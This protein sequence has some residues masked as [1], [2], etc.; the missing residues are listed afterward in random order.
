[1][2]PRRSALTQLPE[3]YLPTRRDKL[4]SLSETARLVN[5]RDNQM[6]R[7]KCKNIGNRNQCHLA[8]SE[9]CSPTTASPGYLNKSEKQD[10]DLK[11]PSHEDDGAL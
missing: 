11:I 4:Q 10:L 6:M 3:L 8:P 9:P 2:P 1:L 5:I 7:G